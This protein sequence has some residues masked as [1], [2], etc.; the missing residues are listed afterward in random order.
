MLKRCKSSIFRV[1][2][3]LKPQESTGID[4]VGADG[5]CSF[6]SI[7]NEQRVQRPG[8][9]SRDEKPAAVKGWSQ[10]GGGEQLVFKMSQRGK[11]NTGAEN[12][13]VTIIW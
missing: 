4:K 3:S 9:M 1:F 11:Y 13:E 6:V 5:A 8:C 2:E 10:G 12:C 7:I